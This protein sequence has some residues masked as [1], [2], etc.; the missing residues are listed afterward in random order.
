[1]NY[2]LF[3]WSHTR[4]LDI[5]ILHC[6]VLNWQVRRREITEHY[7]TTLMF[8]SLLNTSRIMTAHCTWQRQIPHLASISVDLSN[9]FCIQMFCRIWNLK[10]ELMLEKQNIIC[11]SIRAIYLTNQF[12]GFNEILCPDP[13]CNM[14]CYFCFSPVRSMITL[15]YFWRSGDRASW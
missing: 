10:T 5:Y 14:Y 1:M 11:L 3:S 9:L 15:I 12:Q 8:V 7:T 2:I 4:H 6:Y 13:H